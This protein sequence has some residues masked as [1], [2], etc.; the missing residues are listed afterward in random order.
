MQHGEEAGFRAEVSPR[1][2]M[3]YSTIW[4]TIGDSSPFICASTNKS[5]CDLR[6]VRGRGQELIISAEIHT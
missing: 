1:F 3:A 2:G 6:P 5:P 4:L